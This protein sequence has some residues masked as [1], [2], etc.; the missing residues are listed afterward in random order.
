[1]ATPEKYVFISYKA[2]EYDIAKKFTAI[3]KKHNIGYWIA[4]DCIPSGSDYADGIADAIDGCSAFVL[5]L[6]EKSQKSVW[7]KNELK[8]AKDLCKKPIFPVYIE[9]CTL[10]TSIAIYIMSI[11]DC[12]WFNHGS[13]LELKEM[14]FNLAE[15]LGV[16]KAV[17]KNKT[18]QT[19]DKPV[20]R[21]P[22]S[23][24]LKENPQAAQLLTLNNSPVQ[25][26]KPSLENLNT[27]VAYTAE[28]TSDILKSVLKK[29]GLNCSVDNVLQG[30]VAT[31]Y[32]ISVEQISPR[33]V[34]KYVSY[35]KEA[36]NNDAIAVYSNP[37]NMR[38]GVCVEV[39]NVSY[40]QNTIYPLKTMLQ[41]ESYLNA[42]AKALTFAL[43]RTLE[44][45]DVCLD[46][47]VQP[48]MFI[49]GSEKG[50][51]TYLHCLILSMLYKYSPNELRLMIINT[52]DLQLE[53]YNNL[54][55][56]I[57]GRPVYTKYAANALDWV[58]WEMERRYGI[59]DLNKVRNVNDYNALNGVEKLPKI[60]VIIK[61]IGD[62]LA[63]NDKSAIESF[64]IKLSQKSRA[65]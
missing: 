14:L 16:P 26:V 39:S 47:G 56:L 5:L 12:K 44:G 60:L 54:P 35:V 10:A 31:R 20:E 64:I 28:E 61:D 63:T 30:N 21:K 17:E 46:M 18:A 40:E 4:P 51:T 27:P 48:H 53:Y 42:N 3:L 25:Y 15:K 50:S 9:N 22:L 52:C 62:L 1:M 65:A 13:E 32:D 37:S 23:E 49:S 36:L 59:L 24:V 34:F 2:E 7:V 29:R 41:S 11:Q 38:E 58:N 57:T 55:H 43:G 8:V 19:V 45:E 6:S 33:V